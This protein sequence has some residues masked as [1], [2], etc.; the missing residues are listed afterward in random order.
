MQPEFAVIDLSLPKDHPF[1]LDE[2]LIT[3]RFGPPDAIFQCDR[4]KVLVYRWPGS[5]FGALFEHIP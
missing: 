2:D 1:R 3:S 5:A 4:N